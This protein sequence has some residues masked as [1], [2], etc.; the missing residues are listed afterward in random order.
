VGA[1]FPLL[2]PNRARALWGAGGGGGSP[3][4]GGGAWGAPGP[5]TADRVAFVAQEKPCYRS[6]SV[7]DMLKVGR[8]LNR[9]WNQDRALRWLSRFEVPLDRPCGKLSGGQ[10]AQV[11]LAIA[12]G[13]CPTV[14][15]LDEPL[16]NLDPLARRHVT[17]ELLAEVADTRVSVLMSTH[18]VAEL[19]GVADYL[20][21]LAGGRLVLDGDVDELV[22]EHTYYVGPRAAAP[23]DPWPVIRESHLG[24]QSSFLVR[25]PKGAIVPPPAGPWTTRSASFE[26]IIMAYLSKHNEVR[27]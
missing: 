3:P 7:A 5:P 20:L 13:S 21:L 26:D 27:L 9:E 15:L 8:H 11:S 10:Q 18:V 14:L 17:M 23:P 2:I 25:L 12:L 22:A 19:D 1:V 16:A 24:T 6:F 4:A